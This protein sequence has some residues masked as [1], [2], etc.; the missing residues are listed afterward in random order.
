MN[1]AD[2]TRAH[3][4]RTSLYYSEERRYGVYPW[5]FKVGEFADHAGERVLEIGCGTG[6]D[7]LQFAKSG[8]LATG[9]DITQRRLQLARERVGPLA[10]V[11]EASA[12]ELPF[13]DGCFD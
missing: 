8:A 1:A 7:L 6:C 5:L 9:V 13:P 3:W 2:L 12:C 11:Q 10:V 4:N